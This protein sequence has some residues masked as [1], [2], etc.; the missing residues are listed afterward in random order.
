MRNF[1]C[2]VLFGVISLANAQEFNS[3]VTIN[4]EQTGQPNLSVFNTLEIALEEFINKNKWT[5]IE[6]LPQERIDCN[7]FINLTSYD[8]NSFAGTIQV[9]A[10]RPIYNSGYQSSIANFNDKDFSFQ[11]LEYQPLVFNEN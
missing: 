3:D 4:A 2:F 6:Y 9:Q 7:F 1:F 11:Y 8:N 10:S 5:D